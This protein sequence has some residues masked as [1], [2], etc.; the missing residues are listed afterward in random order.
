MLGVD[1]E[2]HDAALGAVDELRVRGVFQRV[3][4]DHAV[5]LLDE[6]V[7]KKTVTVQLLRAIPPKIEFAGVFIFYANMKVNKYKGV[8][9]VLNAA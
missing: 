8:K 2:A 9:Q 6:V 7:C 4:H 3:D 5:R 1:V